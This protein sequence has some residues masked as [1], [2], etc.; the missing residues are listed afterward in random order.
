MASKAAGAPGVVELA[1]ACF[2]HI[3]FKTSVHM[4]LG[5]RLFIHPAAVRR[6][7]LD[8]NCRIMDIILRQIQRRAHA[9]LS[10]YRISHLVKFTPHPLLLNEYATS[11]SLRLE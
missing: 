4:G 2:P 9:P 3:K 6:V 11:C 1:D 10:H 5:L 8:V 7:K